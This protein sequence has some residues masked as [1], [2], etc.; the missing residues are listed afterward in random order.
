M[1]NQNI[2]PMAYTIKPNLKQKIYYIGFPKIWKERLFALEKKRKLSYKLGQS[3]PTTSLQKM[4]NSWMDNIVEIKPIFEQSD[5]SLWL[6]ACSEFTDK[7]IKGLLEMIKFW[8]SAIY[9]A[10]T[11]VM[12]AIKEAAKSL[13][14]EMQI[15]D[16]LVLKSEEEKLL[17]NQDGTVNSEA[18]KAIPL[19]AINAL[20]G[21]DIVVNGTHLH[22]SYV[23]KNEL[24][25][26]PLRD[27]NSGH[28]YSYVMQFSV[29][30]IPPHRQALL[31]CDI[32]IRRWIYSRSNK[33]RP[34]F[35]EDGITVYVKTS[36]SRYYP[37]PIA[38]DSSS[39][40]V[41]WK[42]QE[43]ECY[44]LYEFTQ[45]PS[46]NDLINVV[47]EGTEN[48]LLSYKNGMKGF[49]QSKIGTGAPVG[50]KVAIYEQLFK[51]LEEDV[52]KASCGERVTS[53]ASI[54]CYDTPSK[55]PSRESFREWASLC[56]ETNYIRF[57][58]YGLQNEEDQKLLSAV[59]E[60]IEED[61]GD[62]S[63]DSKLRI[64][65]V[66]KNVGDMCLE[67][68]DSEKQTKINRHKEIVEY[69]GKTEDVVGCI[70]CIPAAEKYNDQQDPKGIV[71]NAFALTGRV[72]QFIN[73]VREKENIKQKIDHAV[74]DL[75]RQIGL[76]FLID[77][78]KY[79]KQ[80]FSQVKC[81]G[82]HVC[83][84]VQGRLNKGRFLPVFISVDLLNGKTR[85]Q[86]SAFG[87]NE[88]SYRQACLK[89][90]DLYW[91]DNLEE[92]CKQASFSP[93]KQKMIEIKNKYEEDSV[94]LVVH[95]DGNTR[96]LWRGI[97]DKVIGDYMSDVKYCPNSIDVGDKSPYEMSLLGTGIR[98]L[99]IRTSGE[100]PDYYTCKSVE[101]KKEDAYASCSGVFKYNE[102][103]WSIAAK[104]NNPV[105]NASLW[106]SRIDHPR[107]DYAEKD[108][109][110]IYPIQLQQGD[111]S[112]KW[113]QYASNLC[114]L[115][116]QYDQKTVL[117]LPL[118]LAKTLAEDY[119]LK[120]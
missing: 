89:M 104:P 19:M 40:A 12:P 32:S 82:M 118:H 50:D 57:E 91:K 111:E 5:D 51:M 34:I 18:Y 95:S 120:L 103:Y 96:P 48:F 86:C 9:V 15:S 117:P 94:V 83:T 90:A 81:V 116:I 85:V 17:S 77:V 41:K 65:I 3:L 47:E 24:I 62:N 75:Y 105:Y 60:K 113:V 27:E 59:K 99:R 7:Q 112:D 28:T 108:M 88:I 29:Q 110:E 101:S 21:K 36:S 31:L 61:F 67:L 20:Q 30:T 52:E 76:A 69:L 2:F 106:D 55:Y 73:P 35:A 13:R 25:S 63:A 68:L 79:S 10:D 114:K 84:Q 4:V 53:R 16:L 87:G 26:Q 72:V 71:R 23:G 37:I 78:D 107:N 38:Y 42:K 92:L 39:N 14:A 119:L 115:S 54:S 56:C 43:F 44:N 64:E 100:V 6:S 8:I 70:C 109:I 102:T 93:V 66:L 45:L 80:K 22:L 98:I 33:D 58:L 11:K 74:Y 46:I 1:A 49:V 97:A